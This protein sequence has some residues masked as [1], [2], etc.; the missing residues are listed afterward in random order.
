MVIH[1]QTVVIPKFGKF[2]N[3]IHRKDFSVFEV[4]SFA[5]FVNPFFRLEEKHGRSGENQVIVPMREGQGEM[6][7]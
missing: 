4:V 7:K 6:D 1:G 5:P 3:L 2:P